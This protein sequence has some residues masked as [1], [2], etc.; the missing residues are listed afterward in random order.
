[1][2]EP[3]QFFPTNWIDGMKI[4]DQHFIDS[5][6]AFRDG[7]RDAMS[8]R[9]TS[10]NYGL[11]T[12][13][14][15]ETSIKCWFTTDNQ[16]EWNIRVTSCRGI[17]PAGG[18][19][20]ITQ[21]TANR[22]TNSSAFIETMVSAETFKDDGLY[23]VVITTNPF[24][25]QVGGTP[26]LEEIPP[27]YPYTHAT[28]TI[29]VAPIVQLP[30]LRTGAYQLVIGQINLKDGIP[31][32]DDDYIPPCAMIK[33]HPKL[34]LLYEKIDRFLSQSELYLIGIMQK[35]YVK[36]ANELAEG[37]WQIAYQVIQYLNAKV[38]Q[39]KHFI[40]EGPP[41]CM[42]EIVAGMARTFKNALDLRASSGKTE[43]L[44]Y[45]W[46]WCGYAPA[47]I[48]NITIKCA[49]LNYQHNNINS[50][51]IPTVSFI[52]LLVK[53]LESLWQ[54]DFIGKKQEGNIFVKEESLQDTEY[55][56]KHKVRNRFFTD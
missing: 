17:T 8:I 26:L 14:Q 39:F 18:R 9:L 23:W 53:L 50:S 7:L 29:S 56:S 10:Y 5:E 15:D 54:L 46:E 37:I 24:C 52:E 44:Q 3:Q 45:F 6:D 27:R 49:N 22:L 1:M 42:L 35:I 43:V 21:H 47:E 48:E 41:V 19:I 38:G 4:R 12:P 13:L 55:L 31:I 28:N 20:E 16:C 33:A 2:I 34:T 32:W 36:Q 11:I 25:R 51:I 30:K 40:L